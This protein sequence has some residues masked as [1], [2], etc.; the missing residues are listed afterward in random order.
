MLLLCRYDTIK[1][2]LLNSFTHFQFLYTIKLKPLKDNKT[3]INS[4]SPPNKQPR[5]VYRNTRC[6]CYYRC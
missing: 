2:T 5:N 6:C 1:K 4:Q 3:N